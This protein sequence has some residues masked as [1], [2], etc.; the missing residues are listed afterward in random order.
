MDEGP[1]DETVELDADS[2][3]ALEYSR[4]WP[5][6]VVSWSIRRRAGDSDFPLARGQVD[7]LPSSQGAMTEEMWAE[8]R[9]QG[10][11]QAMAH[12]QSAAATTGNR[13]QSF[14]GRLLGRR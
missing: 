14:L 9:R 6:Y 12:A 5:K 10:L 1:A 7:V 13:K 11:D 8:L 4:Q 2:W 3:I